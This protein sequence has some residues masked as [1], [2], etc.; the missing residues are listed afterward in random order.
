M[1]SPPTDNL[2]KFMAIFGLVMVVSS[3]VFWWEASN[4]FDDFFESNVEYVN[5]IFESGEAYEKFAKK[6]N[7]RIDIY[8]IVGGNIELLSDEQRQ[9]LD[10]ILVESEELKVKAGAI[11]E[12]NPAARVAMNTR[13]EKYKLAK[14][15][16]ILGLIVGALV[17]IFGFYLWHSR[18]Q[19]YIDQ[20]HRNKGA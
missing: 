11:V 3:I 20:L 5:T 7:E 4:N 13:L 6:T 14:A 2:Y 12:S 9:K 18:L 19:R 17:S 16:S 15:L 10:E 1:I 8:N